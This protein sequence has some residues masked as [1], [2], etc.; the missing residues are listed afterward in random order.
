[1]SEEM[2]EAQSDVQEEAAPVLDHAALSVF[3]DPKDG[4]WKLVSVA[5][6]TNGD[7][8]SY[9]L[10]RTTGMRGEAM[11]WFK[12]ESVRMGFFG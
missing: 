10:V 6:N 12:I 4:Q 5:F 1:M 9:K 11:E 8:G 3:K 7:T 2:K